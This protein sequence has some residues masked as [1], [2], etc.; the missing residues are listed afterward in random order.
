[1]SRRLSTTVVECPLLPHYDNVSATP[2]SLLTTGHWAR[3]PSSPRASPFSSSWSLRGHHT[4][5]CAPSITLFLNMCVHMCISSTTSIIP[6]TKKCNMHLLSIVLLFS[7]IATATKPYILYHNH[8]S[9]NMCGTVGPYL[10]TFYHLHKVAIINRTTP[11]SL[12]LAETNVCTLHSS[13]SAAATH[14]TPSRSSLS[15]MTLA[16]PT[17]TTAG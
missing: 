8:T 4:S 7:A 6:Y 15:S 9:L 12:T 10:M 11:A 1:M 5:V 16:I 3:V 2:T 13:H 17:H 14:T